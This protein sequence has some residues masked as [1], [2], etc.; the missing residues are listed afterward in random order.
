MK[1]RIHLDLQRWKY[2]RRPVVMMA[3]LKLTDIREYRRLYIIKERLQWK[4]R[5]IYNVQLCT[6]YR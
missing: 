4:P 2:L 3:L 6:Q 5:H 1:S